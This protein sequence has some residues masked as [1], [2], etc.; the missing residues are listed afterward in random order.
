MFLNNIEIDLISIIILQ[1]IDS[2]DVLVQILDAR[3]PLGTRCYQVER[4]LKK[5][6]PHKHL[7][8]VLNKVDLVPVWV[9]VS[10]RNKYTPTVP[11]STPSHSHKVCQF[12]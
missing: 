6:K 7:I 3:D 4:Y 11:S 12:T 5:E 2:S 1:V 8:F 10:T 9:T